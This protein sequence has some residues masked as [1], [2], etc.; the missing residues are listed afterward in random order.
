M[1]REPKCVVSKARSFLGCLRMPGTSGVGL[2]LLLDGWLINDSLVVTFSATGTIRTQVL[3]VK[4][5]RRGSQRAAWR[6]Y[7]IKEF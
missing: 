7:G 4:E 6:R 3:L 2:S 5:E 1:S